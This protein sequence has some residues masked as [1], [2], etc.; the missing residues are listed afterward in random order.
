MTSLDGGSSARC[1]DAGQMIS[2]YRKSVDAFEK[3]MV[4]SAESLAATP[5]ASPG[6]LAHYAG[7]LID[8][9][10]PIPKALAE[11][12]SYMS[13]IDWQRDGGA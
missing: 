7:H 6:Q 8:F 13:S 9:G 2:Q 4:T 3:R 1:K 10:L 12:P 11:H 5:G